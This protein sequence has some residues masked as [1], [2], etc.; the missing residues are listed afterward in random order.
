[1]TERTGGEAPTVRL[2]DGRK[3]AYAVYGDPDG[4]PILFFHGTQSSRL[5]RHPDESIA[6]RRAA[7]V[8]VVDRPGH[9]LSDFQP[10][11]RLL[12]WPNDVVELA[13]G[14]GLDRFAVMGMSAGGPYALA[15]AYAIPDRLTTVTVIAGAGPLAVPEVAKHLPSQLK[16][17]FGMARRAPWMVNAM[18]SAQRRRA[19][20]DPAKAVAASIGQMSASDQ[21]VAARPEI[22]AIL[23]AIMAEAYRTGHQGA[24]WELTVLARPWGFEA[25]DISKPVTLW[26][27][28]D[29]RNVPVEWGRYFAA[30][31]PNCTAHFLPGEGH[32]LIFDH[33]DEILAEALG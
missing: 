26:Q 13:D 8:I 7:R 6:R 3:L 18:L 23:P 24:A 28:E 27:G 25:Q 31:L 22:S 19:L 11:R 10:E 1:M 14:L 30:N 20:A 4:T 2:A 16:A 33:F 29:D 12:D 32:L 21:S 15:C 9:G 17:A 5:E